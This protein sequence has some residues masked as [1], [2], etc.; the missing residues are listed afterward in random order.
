MAVGCVKTRWHHN[1]ATKPIQ[2]LMK[3]MTR[4]SPIN[5]T[6]CVGRLLWILLCWIWQVPVAWHW[7]GDGHCAP[8]CVVVCSFKKNSVTRWWVCSTKLSRKC[9]LPLY[10]H[11]DCNYAASSISDQNWIKNRDPLRKSIRF[12]WNP[13]AWLANEPANEWIPIFGLFLFVSLSLQ[14]D[15]AWCL[16]IP[17]WLANPS[18]LQSSQTSPETGIW[19]TPPQPNSDDL[20]VFRISSWNLFEYLCQSTQRRLSCN[21]SFLRSTSL[22]LP[23]GA[24]KRSQAR[25]KSAENRSPL[26]CHF[27][28]LQRNNVGQMLWKCAPCSVHCKPDYEMCSVKLCT[29]Q[30]AM[31]SQWDKCHKMDV[32][33]RKSNS[34]FWSLVGPTTEGTRSMH[35]SWW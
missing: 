15:S 17:C 11:C 19:K 13:K 24:W 18:F 5:S 30:M 10:C 4:S 12:T 33:S 34:Y 2:R 25:P 23:F 20:I 3:N 6:V 21:T 32:N 26:L 7:E 27:E 28:Y 35:R 9:V 8:S 14:H 16:S 29:R 1:A 22:E 31:S